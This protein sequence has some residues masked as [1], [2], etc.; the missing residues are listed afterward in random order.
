[1]CVNISSIKRIFSNQSHY[2]PDIP[3]I[4][5]KAS[6]LAWRIDYFVNFLS[7]N[8][9]AILRRRKYISIRVGQ[10][11]STN[12]INSKLSDTNCDTSRVISCRTIKLF[13]SLKRNIRDHKFKGNCDVEAVEAGRLTIQGRD[14][15]QQAIENLVPLYHKCIGRAVD[16]LWS[17]WVTEAVS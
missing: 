5:C 13:L 16:Y 2:F 17:M 14:G 4:S 7:I 3:C 8:T 6:A 9:Q 15:Y 11:K 12:G 1:M 10:K